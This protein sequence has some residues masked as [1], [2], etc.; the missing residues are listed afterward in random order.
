MHFPTGYD[1]KI[2]Q[3]LH[4]KFTLAFNISLPLYFLLYNTSRI[5]GMSTEFEE[6]TFI[7]WCELANNQTIGVLS[8]QLN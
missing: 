6:V 8:S 4:N 5:S 1:L 2:M 7:S 3:L